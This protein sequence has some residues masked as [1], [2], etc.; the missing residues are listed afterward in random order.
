M[1]T[2]AKPQL[3]AMAVAGCQVPDCKHE[4]DNTIFMHA[5]CHPWVK[6]SV[7]YKFGDG[8]LRVECSECGRPVVNI[9]V[10]DAI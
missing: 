6:P 1:K 3:D 2:L 10:A 5:R 8:F 9:K 7:S 4:H